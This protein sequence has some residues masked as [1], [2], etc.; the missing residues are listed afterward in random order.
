MGQFSTSMLLSDPVK[1]LPQVISYAYRMWIFESLN[2]HLFSVAYC[3]PKM[4]MI[5]FLTGR[6]SALLD[7]TP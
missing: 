5:I 4:Q 2:L 1:Q 7:L 6:V 3:E